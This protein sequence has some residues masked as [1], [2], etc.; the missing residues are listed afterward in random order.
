MP[1]KPVRIVLDTDIGGDIDDLYALYFALFDPRIELAAVT[2]AYGDTQLKAKLVAKALRKAG[3]M[4]IPIGAGIGTPQARVALGE[5]A[6]GSHTGKGYCTYVTE[7][8][9]EFSQEFPSAMQVMKQLLRESEGPVAIVCIGAA[10][11]VADAVLMP[12]TDLRAKISQ[13]A[14]MAGETRR[15]YR[16]YNVVCDPD[17]CEVVLNCGI[18]SFL[19]T[20][21]VTAR[22]RLAM[23]D[24]RREFADQSNPVYETLVTCSE[25]W[26]PYRGHKQ[27]PVLYDLVPLLW[28]A[29]PDCIATC[30][31]TVHVEL[32]GTYTRGM[33][34]RTAED[35]LVTESVDIDAPARMAEILGVL[36]AGA[37]S[38]AAG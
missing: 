33:T 14:L 16:E 8:D 12:E 15:M 1:G 38:V 11:N 25:L 6:P 24:V 20:F 13:T 26:G 9:P 32:R 31:S 17:A 3:C 22:L 36:H 2:T 5:L 18:P 23:D 30:K 35:G 19:G 7:Q 29:N 4:D 28:L 27:G 10:S 37:K 34:V 21:D